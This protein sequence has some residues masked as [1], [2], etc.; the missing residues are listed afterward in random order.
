MDWILCV[1]CV[2]VFVLQFLFAISYFLAKNKAET[3]LIHKI[4]QQILSIVMMFV[5][6][7]N[8]LQIYED[9]NNLAFVHLFLLI[10]AKGKLAAIPSC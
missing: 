3:I 10:D 8:N 1:F 5:F 6:L 7:L 9:N 2:F 4:T